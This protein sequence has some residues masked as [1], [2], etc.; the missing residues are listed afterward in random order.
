MNEGIDRYSTYVMFREKERV[1]ERAF[2]WPPDAARSSSD[3]ENG[4][5][6]SAMGGRASKMGGG[7]EYMEYNTKILDRFHIDCYALVQNLQS[8]LVRLENSIW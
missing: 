5:L 4:Y 2:P 1:W 7:W 8:K 6:V 3:G